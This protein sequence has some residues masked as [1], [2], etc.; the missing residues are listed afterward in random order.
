MDAFFASVEQRDHPELKGKPIAVGGSKLRGV[1]AAASYEA[2]K[3]GVKSAMSSQ[4]AVQLCPELI[5]VKSNFEQYKTVSQ[6]IREIFARFTKLIEPLSLDEAY[7]DITDLPDGY[8]S[9]TEVANAIRTAI[10]NELNLTASA[11]VSYN[12]F[13][14]KLAS[15]VNK[16][17]GCFVI[18]SKDA[19]QFLTELPIRRFYGIGK[20]TAEKF[21]Q[22]G[23]LYGS[24]LYRMSEKKLQQHFGKQAK[25]YYNLVRGIDERIV[26][27]TRE[28]KSM[29]LERTF[30]Y[31]IK[32]EEDLL[33]ELSNLSGLIFKKINTSEISGRTLTVKIKYQDFKQITR[34][35]TQ[36][37]YYSTLDQIKE[38]ACQLVNENGILDK[39]IRLLGISISN[40]N[41]TNKKGEQ[42]SLPF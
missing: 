22:L 2:R 12:K 9:A 20:V 19:H 1:V 6:S 27:P 26:K 17:N 40:F 35:I 5:F 33:E 31:N 13:L 34:S 36:E 21:K 39:E 18:K 37:D 29:G 23:I 41:K 8:S 38:T 10:F 11:G 16:P 24:D 30:G 25:L 14:A 32:S 4:K 42:I 28:R 7:L 15:D 3:Y